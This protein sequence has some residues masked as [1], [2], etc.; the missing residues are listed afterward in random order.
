MFYPLGCGI[1]GNLLSRILLTGGI[2]VLAFP[3]LHAQAQDSTADVFRA[4]PQTWFEFYFLYSQ[5]EKLDIYGDVSYRRRYL[6]GAD[7]NR[8]TI[9][10][11]ARYKFSHRFWM[12]GGFM[13]LYTLEELGENNLEMRLWQGAKAK[14]PVFRWPKHKPAS[15]SHFLRFEQRWI[16]TTDDWASRFSSRSRYQVSF[17]F[18]LVFRQP[19][20]S[21][22]FFLTSMFETFLDLGQ[23]SGFLQDAARISVGTGYVVNYSWTPSFEFVWQR[24]RN[25]EGAIR[26]SDYLMRFKISWNFLR[27]RE[28]EPVE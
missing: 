14:W 17:H 28:E 9:R 11:S 6:D 2:L 22:Y 10:P 24:S 15:I 3:V 4:N 23:A 18:P 26:T 19:K 13:A 21:R 5:T 16:F 7:F 20:V 27:W 25:E 12:G 8:F 1:W